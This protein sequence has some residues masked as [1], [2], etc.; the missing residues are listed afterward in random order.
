[1]RTLQRPER[2]IRAVF[3]AKTITVYQGYAP[4]IG[5]PAVARGRFPAHY[6]RDHMTWIKPSF[7]W[8]MYRSSWARADGQERV[9]AIRITREGLHWALRHAAL[10]SFHPNFHASRDDWRAELRRLPV[11]VQWD[12]ERDLNLRPL[13]W[14]SLQIGLG[15]EAV[16]RYLDSWIV[17][18]HDVTALAHRVQGLVR[19]REVARALERLPAERPYPLPHDIIDRVDASHSDGTTR[20]S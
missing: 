7:L 4:E 10:S 6:D 15:G 18:I 14:R 11:R 1:M 9:L 5:V 17:D 16:D 12:P 19:D 13:P 3:D 20:V 2:Q 8:M